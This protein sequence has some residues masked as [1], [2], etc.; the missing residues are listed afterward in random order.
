MKILKEYNEMEALATQWRTDRR[1]ILAK[2]LSVLKDID[3]MSEKYWNLS[4]QWSLSGQSSSIEVQ[5][6]YIQIAEA[7]EILHDS[8]S[9]VSTNLPYIS[10]ESK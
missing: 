8:L 5:S 1:S 9:S 6:K 7:L 2:Y 3:K 4:E 10:K